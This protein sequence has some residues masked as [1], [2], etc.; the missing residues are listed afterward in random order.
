MLCNEVP[1]LSPA[2][3]YVSH[4]VM[5]VPQDFQVLDVSNGTANNI[6]NYVDVAAMFYSSVI[7]S[8]Y[9]SEMS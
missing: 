2:D 5:Q 4:H 1:T 3:R 8:I 6:E 7:S 9:T